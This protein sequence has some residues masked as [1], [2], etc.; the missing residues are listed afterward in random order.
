MLFSKKLNL[1]VF[2]G[3]N[4]ISVFASILA[5]LLALINYLVTDLSLDLI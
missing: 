2:V 1:L 3:W 5:R 4:L